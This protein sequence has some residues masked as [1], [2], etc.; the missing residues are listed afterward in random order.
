MH[1]RFELDLIEVDGKETSSLNG[2][3]PQLVLR[4][5]LTRVRRDGGGAKA[6]IVLEQGEH[7]I[8]VHFDELEAAVAALGVVIHSKR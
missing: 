8:T 1:M 3:P 2:K 6:A 4:D 5:H 7:S